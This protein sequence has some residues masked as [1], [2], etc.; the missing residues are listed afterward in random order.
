M[1]I[2]DQYPEFKNLT[3]ADFNAMISEYHAKVEITKQQYEE[4]R[5][6][7]NEQQQNQKT[8]AGLKARKAYLD[9]IKRVK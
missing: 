2:K 7:E 3:E 1:N 9:E 6:L 5:Q 8:I 4:I